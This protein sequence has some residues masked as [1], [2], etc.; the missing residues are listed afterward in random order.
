MKPRLPDKSARIE[1]I[2]K[3]IEIAESYLDGPL[4]K[5]AAEMID[6]LNERLMMAIQ[7]QGK[8]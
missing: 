1:R 6:A 3:N 5:L 2:I 7:S 4:I 8:G